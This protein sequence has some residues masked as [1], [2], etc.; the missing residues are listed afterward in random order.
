MDWV[1]SLILGLVQGLTEFLPVSSD[2][3]LTVVQKL[4]AWGTGRAR[5][6]KENL[7]LDVVL[8]LGTLAAIVVHYR[9]QA[10]A[11][12]RGFLL[13]STDVAEDFRR[14]AVFRVGCLAAVATL[15]LI[16]YLFGLKKV[17]EKAIESPY[18]TGLGFLVTA[19]VL[20]ISGWLKGGEKGPSETTW[21]DALL[22]GVAQAFA[23]LPGVSRSGLTIATAL[24][25]GLKRTWAVNFSLMLAV[26]A[27]LGAA[28]K[29]F[30]DLDRST[31]SAVPI[32]PTLAATV[33]SGLVGYLAIVW[34][35]RIVRAGR[36][37]YFSVY[38]VALGVVL[39][40]LAVF[41][42]G[43]A[44]NGTDS[45]APDR[46][47]RTLAPSPGDRARP[48]RRPGTVAGPRTS[49]PRSPGG[50]PRPEG[51]RAEPGDG[52]DVG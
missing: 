10:I 36:L 43:G 18:A 1:E 51:R 49:G 16:P 35:V 31:L 14:S 30:K 44:G 12:A 34:L 7:F 6:G 3:H 22:I 37:W 5:T 27:I 33:V 8:H 48:D 11:G 15:P 20:A 28:A 26:P 50:G 32:A 47:S 39:L 4:F 24:A 40:G 17:I 38:L 23:P 19:A 25:L 41:G 45:A 2:G 29:E 42:G 21:L 13:N 46:P 52:L 9:K